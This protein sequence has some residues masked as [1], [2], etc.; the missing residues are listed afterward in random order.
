LHDFRDKPEATKC[1]KCRQRGR[2]NYFAKKG[3]V[4][5][6]PNPHPRSTSQTKHSHNASAGVGHQHHLPP[7]LADPAQAAR[8]TTSYDLYGDVEESLAPRLTSNRQKDMQKNRISRYQERTLNGVPVGPNAA[9]YMKNAANAANMSQ[10]GYPPDMM[11]MGFGPRRDRSNSIN[12]LLHGYN[13][14]PLDFQMYDGG[15]YDIN[16][17]EGEDSRSRSNTLL[18]M[19]GSMYSGDDKNKTGAGAEAGAGTGAGGRVRTASS[20]GGGRNRT[21]SEEWGNLAQASAAGQ[22]HL[23]SHDMFKD[24]AEQGGGGGG[25]S[26]GGG[27]GGFQ[28]PGAPGAG[29][30]FAPSVSNGSVVG[31]GG[32]GD[33]KRRVS[34]DLTNYFSGGWTAAPAGDV[35]G[36]DGGPGGGEAFESK[37]A[38]NNSISE[39]LSSII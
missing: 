7:N 31:P 3:R 36:G 32:S 6:L 10:S 29:V 20:G 11:M 18:S 38:R 21:T 17:A 13:E 30:A 8:Y 16:D 9:K 35:D 34:I 19:T 27:G 14:L 4:D 25:G 37:R 2:Q 15:D 1:I 5:V 26:G 12:S 24:P 22:F 39:I 33:R 23:V 28:A